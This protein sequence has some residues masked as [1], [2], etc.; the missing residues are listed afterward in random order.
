M[1]NLMT[2]MMM[3]LMCNYQVE[4]RSCMRTAVSAR[5]WTSPSR[6]N[7]LNRYL[8][9]FQSSAMP[10]GKGMDI[11]IQGEPAQQVHSQLS[12]FCYACTVGKGMDITIQ[13]EP[14]QQ[15][16]SQLSVF[17]YACRLGHGHHHPG[18]QVHSQLSVLSYAYQ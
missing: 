18:G 17:S 14:A 3:M 2:M 7:Q 16:H 6:G 10:V 8:A 13:G 15:V 5:A 4:E 12:V 11:T 9:S 1:T